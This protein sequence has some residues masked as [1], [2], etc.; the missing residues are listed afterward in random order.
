MARDTIKIRA[1]GKLKPGI[2]VN[3]IGPQSDP[4]YLISSYLVT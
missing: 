2:D 4:S 3:Q 1:E